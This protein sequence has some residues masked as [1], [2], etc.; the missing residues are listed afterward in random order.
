MYAAVLVSSALFGATHLLNFIQGRKPLLDT[1]TQITFAIFFGVMFSACFLRNRT[2]WPVILL[3]A[4]VDWAGT[5]DEIAVGGGLHRTVQAMS[6]GNALASILIT[7][8]LFLYGLFILRKVQPDSL[9][10]E[11]VPS[12]ISSPGL[13]RNPPQEG[14]VK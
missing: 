3:H 1:A 7:L 5:L 8:P 2:I 10:V 6:P 12:S 4:A 14:A 13:T 11:A 9:E